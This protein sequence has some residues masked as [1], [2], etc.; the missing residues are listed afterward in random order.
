MR[1]II[2]ENIKMFGP[3]A[4]VFDSYKYMQTFLELITRNLPNR[5][6]IVAID[7]IDAVEAAIIL[8]LI[9]NLSSFYDLCHTNANYNAASILCRAIVDGVAVLKLIYMNTDEEERE[10]RHF[11]YVLDGVR[12]RAKLLEMDVRYNGHISLEEFKALEEQINNAKKNTNTTISFCESKLSQHPY[13]ALHPF[14]EL[15]V[16]NAIWQFKKVGQT[17][18]K[19]V[20]KYQWKEMYLLLDNREEIVSMY[21]NFLSQFVHGLSIS[22]LLNFEEFENF[23]CLLTIGVCL[24]GIIVNELMSRYNDNRELYDGFTSNDMV[25]LLSMQSP[26]SRTEFIDK[27]ANHYK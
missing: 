24:Q 15:V 3:N 23:E 8:K 17:S 27:F 7:N 20:P 13:S 11:L 1:I 19:C 6:P 25:T 2:P 16:K 22:N 18:N 9:K 12:E 10:Y 5:Y 26:E 14:H 4:S 21:S